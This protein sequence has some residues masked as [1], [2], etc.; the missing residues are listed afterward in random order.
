MRAVLLASDSDTNAFLTAAFSRVDVPLEVAG[1]TAVLERCIR[2][3]HADDLVALN[4][5]GSVSECL[6]VMQ[7]IQLQMVAL[8][9]SAAVRQRL[10]RSARGPVCWL[11]L[12]VSWPTLLATLR[13]FRRA[14]RAAGVALAEKALTEQQL[15]VLQLVAANHS[16]R[17]ISAMLGVGVGTVK[18]HVDRLKEK[19]DVASTAELKAAFSWMT[20]PSSG[21]TGE[22]LPK[23]VI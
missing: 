12:S 14:N 3:A 22:R 5:A 16:Q 9:E 2:H 1:D 23:L 10:A 7:R 4:C 18:R 15:R 19:L 8:F 21:P 20:V 17:E 11:P 13:Q 6:Y